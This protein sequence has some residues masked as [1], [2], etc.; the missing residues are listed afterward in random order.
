MKEEIKRWMRLADEDFDS[1]KINFYNKK[2]YVCA[3]LCQQCAEKSLKAL[4]I[5]KEEK[6]PKVHDL[7]FLGKKIG[8]NEDLLKECD[9]LSKVYIETRY[10]D[11]GEKLPFEKFDKIKTKKFLE[12]SEKLLKWIKKNI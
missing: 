10:P 4:F 3:F 2:Y 1:A 7:V 12:I 9:E 8:L 6:V 5:K 11:V